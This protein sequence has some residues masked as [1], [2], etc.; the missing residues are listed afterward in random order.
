MSKDINE[1]ISVDSLTDHPLSKLLTGQVDEVDAIMG[2]GTL[3][4]TYNNGRVV[5]IGI[6]A[7]AGGLRVRE[8]KPHTK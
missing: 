2:E 7:T 8:E 1:V 4:L 3:L 5:S 6:D